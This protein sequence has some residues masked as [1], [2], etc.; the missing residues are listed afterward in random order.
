MRYLRYENVFPPQGVAGTAPSD[1]VEKNRIFA[2]AMRVLIVCNN[3]YGR[4]NGLCASARTV[5]RCLKDRGI[6][7]RV[8]SQASLIP[9][10]PLPDYTLKK[11][12]FPFFQ[13]L[14]ES[15]SFCFA[16]SD[17]EIMRQ[18]IEWADVIHLEE[19]F[20][21][22]WKT[23]RMAEKMH[24]P[25]VATFHLYPENI[26]SSVRLGGCRLL[27]AI[28]MNAF[29]KTVF[30][31]CSDI[32]CPTRNV[33]DRLKKFRFKSELHLISN[34]I[35][36]RDGILTEEPDTTPYL[37]MC[38]G[39][40]SNEKDQYTLLRAMR[41]SAHSNTVQLF[42]AGQG[43]TEKRLR[44]MADRLVADGVLS[45]KPIFEFHNQKALN[46]IERRAYLNIHCARIEVEGLSC[47]EAMR[48][49]VVP[50]IA[51]G[52]LTATSQFALDGRSVFPVGDAAALAS[53]IDWWI[54]HPEERNAMARRYAESVRK[55]NLNDS[56]SSLIEMYGSAI[57]KFG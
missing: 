9:D 40:F 21:L 13:K 37:I 27:N 33:A 32:Q 7:V 48:E 10:D 5:F 43:P 56:I 1:K 18:A 25:C 29:R 34:G 54:E 12:R 49:G 57:S 2:T 39:R 31:R 8:M 17:R 16:S 28:L 53:R 44:R 41:H 11:Y 22:Q 3:F 14:I 35:R 46:T 47:L 4:G 19:A 30:D 36:I 24:V 45:Y 42:F 6:D 51:D 26:L 50:V 52:E 20:V 23:A 38:V 55:Y 15:Q